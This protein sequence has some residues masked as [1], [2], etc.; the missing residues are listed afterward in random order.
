MRRYGRAARQLSIAKGVS[1]KTTYWL[2]AML[3]MLG[4]NGAETT[5]SV[6]IKL[7]AAAGYVAP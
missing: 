7:G 4:M 2:L 5:R 3:S 6:Q 1:R